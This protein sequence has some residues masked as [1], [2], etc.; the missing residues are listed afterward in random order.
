MVR[1]LLTPSRIPESLVQVLV[2]LKVAGRVFQKTFAADADLEYE[3]GWDKVNVYNQKVYG[4]VDA[5]VA[6]GY[7]YSGCAEPI[8]TARVVP[9]K[10]FDVDIAHVGGGWNIDMHHYYNAFQGR[11][12]F[13]H[14]PSTRSFV[15][16]SDKHVAPH[17]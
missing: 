1:I 3:F 17:Y 10:G 16:S 9:L 15:N 7:R 11:R 13:S 5:V 6:V 12:N 4:V 14:P 8:W 2:N